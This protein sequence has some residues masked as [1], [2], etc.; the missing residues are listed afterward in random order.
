MK[1][2]LTGASGFI[3]KNILE[4]KLALKYEIA[5]PGRGDLDLTSEVSVARFFSKNKIDCVIHG[6]GKPGHR[7]APDPSNILYTDMRMFLNLLQ[8]SG[9][10]KKML[11]LSSGAVYD[12]RFPIKRAKEESY[13]L[14]VPTDEHA[15]FRRVTAD[16]IE[17][18]DKIVELRIFGIFGPYEDYAIRFISSAIC[19]T[20]LDLPITLKQNRKFDY[21]FV[22]D[23]MPILDYFI[24]HT[25]DHKAY[26]ITPDKPIELLTLAKIVQDVSGKNLPINVA[27]EGLGPEYSGDNSRLKNEFTGLKLSPIDLSIL[28]LY[29]W[30]SDNKHLINKDSLLAD[31]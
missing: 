13:K 26:N 22:D 15:L 6:A 1:I 11:V 31:K 16:Y 27:Q 28:K 21:I 5:A 20:F 9:K 14:H 12:Q 18:S 10:Y 19:K 30:Y 8:N 25:V 4:S 23:L 2:L 3:G 7:N 24:T 29:S 17:Q